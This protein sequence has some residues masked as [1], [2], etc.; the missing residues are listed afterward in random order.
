MEN[1]DKVENE[2][3]ETYVLQAIKESNGKKKLHLL[4]DFKDLYN[5]G[6]LQFTK[7]DD[8]KRT[9]YRYLDQNEQQQTIEFYDYFHHLK[10][11]LF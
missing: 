4:L 5:S 10:K 2:K 11:T 6:Q 3:I 7:K 8:V 9:T 1:K